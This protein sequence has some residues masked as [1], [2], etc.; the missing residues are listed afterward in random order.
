MKRRTHQKRGEE[1]SVRWWRKAMR[2][3]EGDSDFDEFS[4]RERDGIDEATREIVPIG[5]LKSSSC[6][7][8]MISQVCL[9]LWIKRIGSETLE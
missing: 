8:L 2:V 7:G 3:K 5:L 6:F 1:F 9:D 4:R